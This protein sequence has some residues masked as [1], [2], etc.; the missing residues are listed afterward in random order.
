MWT[1]IIELSQEAGKSMNLAELQ[2]GNKWKESNDKVEEIRSEI[3]KILQ[4]NNVNITKMSV[5]VDSPRQELIVYGYYRKLQKEYKNFT[6][7]KGIM[8][9]VMNYY[10]IDIELK[11]GDMVLLSKGE[12]GG[13]M[14][15]GMAAAYASENRRRHDKYGEYTL[16]LESFEEIKLFRVWELGR[17]GD[18]FSD[19]VGLIDCNAWHLLRCKKKDI[20]RVL[21]NVA[22]PPNRK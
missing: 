3:L 16:M 22:Y 12:Y 9:L 5:V 13:S 2:N 15:R 14:L 8:Q 7:V 21:G 10:D 4:K 6:I 1:E 18:P 19:D 20:L 11:E 17:F